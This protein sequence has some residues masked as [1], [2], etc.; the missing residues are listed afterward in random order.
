[1]PWRLVVRRTR[2]LSLLYILIH[3]KGSVPVSGAEAVT[4]GLLADTFCAAGGDAAWDGLVFSTGREAGV[5]FCEAFVM[6]EVFLAWTNVLMISPSSMPDLIRKSTTSDLPF[7]ISSK[8]CKASALEGLLTKISTLNKKPWS[9]M[10]GF[11]FIAFIIH[12]L[13]YVSTES[14][15][16]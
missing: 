14:N 5:I 9:S 1:M 4:G 7:S 8:Y 15:I 16:P 11:V 12:Q 13:S 6:T 10:S 3:S 2:R